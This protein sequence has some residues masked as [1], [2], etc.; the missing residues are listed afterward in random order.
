LEGFPSFES[1]ETA[2]PGLA[3]EKNRRLEEGL[4]Q[5]RRLPFA[6]HCGVEATNRQ[7]DGVQADVADLVGG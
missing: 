6:W 7:I 3:I 1:Q 2:I 4:G 5:C